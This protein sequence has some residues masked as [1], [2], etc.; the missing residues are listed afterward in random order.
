MSLVIWSTKPE[1]YVRA[2]FAVVLHEFPDLPVVVVS[3]VTVLPKIPGM[4]TL[5]ALGQE[6]IAM[7]ASNLVIPKNRTATSLRGV[8][9]L[10]TIP[11]VGKVNAL[12][13][14][15]PGVQDMDYGRYIQLQ[16]DLT[17]AIRLETTGSLS[18]VYGNYEYVPDLHSFRGMIEAVWE[19]FPLR[20]VDVALDLETVGLDPWL[21]PK[22][23]HPGAYI[24]SI[25]VSAEEGTAQVVYFNNAKEEQNWFMTLEFVEDLIWILT[26]TKIRLRGANLKYD[27]TWLWVRA[28][29]ECTNFVF[30]TT[31]VGSLLDENRSNALDVHCKLYAAPLGGYSDLVDKTV[32]K[33]R[34]DLVPRDKL[35]PYAAGDADATLRVARQMK[36]QLLKDKQ[37]TSF[38][39]NILHPAA[40]AFEIVERGGCCVDPKAFAELEVDLDKEIAGLVWK[41][42]NILGGRI[43]AKHADEDKNGGMNLTKASMLCD[44]MFSPMGLNLKPLELT[45]GGK[46]GTGPKLPSTAIDHLLQFKDVPEASEFI[47]LLGDYSSASKTLSTF[48]RGFQKHIRSDGRL[49]PTYWFFAG[50]KDEGDGGTNSGRLSAR[51]PAWQTLP[52]HTKWAKR[53][54]YCYIAPSGHVVVERDYNQGE[55]RVHACIAHEPNMIKAY[56]MGMDLHALTSGEFSGYNYEAMMELKKTNKALFDAIRQLGKAGNF[57]LL[58]GMSAGGF[59]VYAVEN[60]GV[61][62]FTMDKSV[63]FCDGFFQRYPG[64]ITYNEATKLHAHK[65]GYVRSPLGRIRHLPLI[66]SPN[67]QIQSQA[68]RQS[69]NAPTQGCLSDLL[70]WT[71]SEENHNGISAE[72]P[73][74]GACHDAAYSYVLE[75][76]VALWV[77]KALGVMENLPFNKVGWEPELKF[78]A[79]AKFG[80]NMGSL[81]EW[82]GAHS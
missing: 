26:N 6:P 36:G 25:Q 37:L 20:M 66:N 61:K 49:H 60:Y 11:F 53:L 1:A 44:F 5:F 43:W 68:E 54:R 38:Y 33:A 56:K 59:F 64:L 8:P 78:L 29:V 24:V 45:A 35:L 30:D 73:C 48:V 71:I 69:I 81:T 72:A 4:T 55:L 67:K 21:L 13:S 28:M 22:D 57:G 63:T 39:V 82:K 16:C 31:L 23:K 58:Y 34:M 3:D 32:D 70:L 27:L 62:D 42:R 10:M 19:E 80:P 47:A 14:Y 41:A 51:D 76:K 17:S 7:L 74:F 75:D 40:R 50:N 65:Y 12:V 79:D 2:A 46:D 52:K 18:P 15:D 77:P 9:H